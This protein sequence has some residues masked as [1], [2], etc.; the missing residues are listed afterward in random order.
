MSYRGN[1]I[2]SLAGVN[3]NQLSA[4]ELIDLYNEHLQL[5]MHGLCFSAYVEGQEPGD[6]LTEEQVRRRMQIIKPYTKWVRSFSCT[7]GNE[8]IPRIAK[9]NGLKTLV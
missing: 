6:Q 8:M 1:K 2:M 4:D 7:D 5:G 9:E 3:T